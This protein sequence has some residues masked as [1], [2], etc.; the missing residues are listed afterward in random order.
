[1]TAATATLVRASVRDEKAERLDPD[2]GEDEQVNQDDVRRLIEQHADTRE[3]VDRLS[4]RVH[5]TMRDH[6][7]AKDTLFGAGGQLGTAAAVEVLK[8]RVKAVRRE[9]TFTRRMVREAVRDLKADNALLKLA[10]E[11]VAK[12]SLLERAV[13]AM[14]ALAFVAYVVIELADKLG[15]LR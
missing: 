11:A 4:E 10:I 1:M 12:R 2:A 15:I 3:A 14:A 6:Q 8:E 13:S 5:D 7:I 9:A